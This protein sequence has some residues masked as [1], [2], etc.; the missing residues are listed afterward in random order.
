MCIAAWNRSSGSDEVFLLKGMISVFDNEGLESLRRR[1]GVQPHAMKRFLNALFKHCAD[2]AGVLS[3]LPESA[4]ADFEAYIDFYPLILEERRDS[5]IDGAGKLLFRTLDGYPVESV[6]LR[7]ATGRTSLCISS[8]VGCAC[9]CRFCATGMMG[10]RRNLTADEIL[11]QVRQAGQ[12]LRQEGRSIRNVVFMGMGEPLLNIGGVCRALGM[13]CSAPHFNYSGS[14]IMVSTVG[15]P[16]E[17]ERLSAEFPD[18]QMALSLHSARQEVRQKLMPTAACYPLEMLKASLSVV[19]KRSRVMVEYLM[20]SEVNDSD[21]DLE[22]MIRFLGDLPVHINI[23]P[24]NEYAG[25]TFRG[26]SRSR[27]ETFAKRLRAAGYA[28]TLRYSM[29]SDIAA[30]CGQLAQQRGKR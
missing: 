20:L 29:G 10:F 11:D 12:L 27:R 26:S 19:S 30:A 15:I 2:T 18:V 14:R 16:H 28:T 4:R 21:A 5:A 9:A 23:I 8:Q 7:P 24:F 17:M 3:E 13:L 22:S 6:V 25:C 1:N